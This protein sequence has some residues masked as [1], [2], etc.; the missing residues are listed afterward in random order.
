[1]V[2]ERRDGGFRG[3]RGPREGSNEKEGSKED[4][5][6][7]SFQQFADFIKKGNLKQ[8]GRF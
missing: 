8:K 3:K 7:A 4:A 6:L 2:I 5:W 1:M